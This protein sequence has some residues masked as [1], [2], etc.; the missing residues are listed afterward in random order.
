MVAALL[1]TSRGFPCEPWMVCLRQIL[2]YVFPPLQYLL[3]LK[4]HHL[5]LLLSTR[6]PFH[7]TLGMEDQHFPQTSMPACIVLSLSL[8]WVTAQLQCTTQATVAS[9]FPL[10]LVPS[11]GHLNFR[12][13]VRVDMVGYWRCF[14]IYYSCSSWVR[15]WSGCT[16]TSGAVRVIWLLS[17]PLFCRQWSVRLWCA[18]K[19][20]FKILLSG[21]VVCLSDLG[22]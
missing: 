12:V 22:R 19:E 20:D 11:V 18:W 7:T 16:G 15:H 1:T 13:D 3:N 4:P 2:F 5:T 8:S 17:V 9:F 14:C 10:N 21:K 6:Q